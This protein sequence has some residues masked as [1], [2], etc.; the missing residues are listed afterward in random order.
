[1]RVYSFG[2]RITTWAV[3]ALFAWCY[4]PLFQIPQAIA[5]EQKASQTRNADFGLQNE[6]QKPEDRFQNAFDRIKEGVE[7]EDVEK[8]KTGRAE[9]ESYDAELK[10]QFQDTEERIKSLPETVKQR[11]R[12]FVAKY[13]EN[14]S[15]LKANLDKIETAKT[16]EE[17]RQANKTAKA[18]LEKTKKKSLHAPLDPDRLPHRTIRAKERAPRLKKEEFERDFPSQKKKNNIKTAFASDSH[19]WPRILNAALNKPVLLAFNEIA[20]DVPLSLVGSAGTPQFAFSET[21]PFLLA[22]ATDAPTADDLAEAPPAIQFTSDIRAKAQDELGCNPTKIYNWVRNNILYEPYYGSFKSADQTLLEGAGNDTDQSGLLISL[23]RV[24]NIASKFAYGTVEIPAEKAANMVGVSDPTSAATILATQ[25]IPVKLVISGGKV[26]ALRVE[27]AWVESWIDYFPS[28]GARHKQ[29][30]EDTWIPLDPAFK[31]LTLMPGMDIYAEM[32]FNAE[33]FLTS[34]ITDTRDITAY[35]DYSMRMVDFIDTNYPDAT[36]EE[37][38]GASDIKSSRTIIT[39][40]FPYLLGTLP[41]KVIVKAAEFSQMPEALD[42]AITIQIEGNSSDG[43]AGLNYSGYLSSLVD[44]RVTVSYEAATSADEALVTQYGGNMLDVPPYLLTVK[45]V[46][47]IS[48]ATVATGASIGLGQDQNIMI[49]FAGPDGDTDRVQNVITAG[50]YS[51]I[52]LQAQDTS[53]KIPSKNMA[54]LVDNA[55]NVGASGLTLDDLLGQMLYSIGVSYFQKLSFEN[56]VYAKTLQLIN[57]RQ[58]AE[59]M[60]THLVKVSYLFGMP[61]SVSEDGISIDVDRNINVVVSPTQDNERI[62]AF[63]L[64]SGLSSSVWENRILEAFFDVPSVSAVRLLKLASEQGVPVHT[65]TNTNLNDILSQLQ[66]SSEVKS[67]I[68]NA[69]NAGKKVIIS[70][71]NVTYNQWNG[72]GYIVINPSSGAAGY[73]ISGGMAGG[74][75]ATLLTVPLR[76][77]LQ[78]GLAIF[79]YDYWRT[80]WIRNN[81]LRTVRAYID[82]QYVWGGKTDAGFDCSGLVH[83]V[84]ELVGIDLPEGNADNQYNIVNDEGWLRAYADRL[85]GDILW[86]GD[87]DAQKEH[88]GIYGGINKIEWLPD[89]GNIAELETVI[90]ASGRPCGR[91]NSCVPVEQCV[92][93]N[94]AC[95]TFRRVIESPIDDV[96]GNPTSKVGRPR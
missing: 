44:Q 16:K 51:A 59:A 24:C 84:F 10:K 88:T 43:A 79:A 74:A 29:G 70:K 4:G 66:V 7:K 2:F 47:K 33:E 90:H 9:I 40:E 54:T 45:P 86:R 57:S 96:F 26:T 49:S 22:Q 83:E 20:S 11:H 91:R 68:T 19:G 67:D 34:Y 17:K 30:G 41:Y 92:N 21:E 89:S 63:M 32:G 75:L 12:E 23:M 73:M 52:V 6:R 1:M 78:V 13:E 65:I 93:G 87:V 31:Q 69:V 28:W 25:G 15:A 71:T 39:Q 62:K 82:T 35:Q 8:L 53:T 36:I 58:P 94:P 42:Y 64:L 18:F 81:V 14:L 85:S 72:V 27:R 3:L 38:F 37:V 46:L 50:V 77:D 95:G 60:V 61:R 5:A 56:D 55:K 76:P 80:Y 48:G